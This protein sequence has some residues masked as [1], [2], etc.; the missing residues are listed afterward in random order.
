MVHDVPKLGVCWRNRL[1]PSPYR[2]LSDL[3][4]QHDNREDS[5]EVNADK[6]DLENTG[7][8]KRTKEAVDY[9]VSGN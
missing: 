5:W 4:G 7:R 1:F 3:V 8:G 2:T 6:I 9:S